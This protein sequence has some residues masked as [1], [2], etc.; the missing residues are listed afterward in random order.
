LR[1]Y[2]TEN[3]TRHHCKHLFVNAVQG[4]IPV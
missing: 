1:P 2:L 3:S 4:N